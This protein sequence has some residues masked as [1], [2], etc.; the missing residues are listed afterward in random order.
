MHGDVTTKRILYTGSAM[1]KNVVIFSP[2]PDDETLA[3]GGT[4]VKKLSEG[5]TISIVFMTDGRHSL[6]KLFGIYSDPTPM[7][8]KEI[9]KR[10]AIRAAKILGLKEKNLFFLDFEDGRLEKTDK[11]IKKIIEILIETSPVE[12]YFPW[13]YDSPNDH[14]ITSQIVFDSLMK[15]KMHIHQ[16][17]YA[18]TPALLPL[19]PVIQRP[20]LDVA[21][22][23]FKSHWLEVDI[24]KFIDLKRRAINAYQS[25]IS[26]LSCKQSKPVLDAFFLKNFLKAKEKFLLNKF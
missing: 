3:C 26:V 11:T 23:I 6:S 17:Q 25:Q 8:L 13:A 19:S 12:V 24:S 5:Y 1:E 9:R 4:I 15:L 21:S 2:H 20:L 14:K 16:Y 7:E 18:I 22:R 10:E